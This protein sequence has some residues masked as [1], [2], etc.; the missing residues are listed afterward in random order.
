M[1]KDPKYFSRMGDCSLWDASTPCIDPQGSLPGKPI[2]VEYFFCH[3]YIILLVPV[4]GTP[5]IKS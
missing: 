1:I 5:L 2:Q 4:I 3:E